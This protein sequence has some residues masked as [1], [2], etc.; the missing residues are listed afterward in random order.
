LHQL[1]QSI[2]S[3]LLTSNEDSGQLSLLF[4]VVAHCPYYGLWNKD[5]EGVVGCGT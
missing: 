4:S 3:K 2:L 1:L 5:H